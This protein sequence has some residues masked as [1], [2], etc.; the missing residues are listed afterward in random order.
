MRLAVEMVWDPAFEL[1]EAVAARAREGSFEKKSHS[2][3]LFILTNSLA[4]KPATPQAPVT[5]YTSWLIEISTR[6]SSSSRGQ[7]NLNNI[8]ISL[9]F[10]KNNTPLPEDQTSQK[11]AV[12]KEL[13]VAVRIIY[14]M[15]SIQVGYA[16]DLGVFLKSLKSEPL[17]SSI[18]NLIS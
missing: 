8:S 11:T 7:H 3:R 2:S 16:P 17:E 18:E 1:A 4:N 12:Y 15:P 9:K 5:S 10:P 6:I 13:S 14:A